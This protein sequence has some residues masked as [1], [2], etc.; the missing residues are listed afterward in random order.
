LI[1]DKGLACNLPFYTLKT[2]TEGCYIG[3]TR[4]LIKCNWSEADLGRYSLGIYKQIRETSYTFEK[5]LEVKSMV[6]ITNEVETC[7]RIEDEL[8]KQGITWIHFN[9]SG[10][11]FLMR[12]SEGAEAKLKS[13]L[14]T[15]HN[16]AQV[17]DYLRNGL[18]MVLLFSLTSNEHYYIVR[19]EEGAELRDTVRPDEVI[20]V[21]LHTFCEH[22]PCSECIFVYTPP[23]NRLESSDSFDSKCPINKVLKSLLDYET[24]KINI[25]WEYG[26]TRI[27]GVEFIP[28]TGFGVKYYKKKIENGLGKV[29]DSED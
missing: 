2:L 8:R 7:K 25:N 14:I 3:T 20:G 9:S 12:R 10:V 22:C 1:K 4:K 29:P 21:L 5:L 19:E 16:L 17:I 13:P 27:S 23:W 18:S 28:D 24:M 15:H 11:D 26:N 6:D